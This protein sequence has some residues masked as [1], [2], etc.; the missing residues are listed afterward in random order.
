MI[1]TS[2]MSATTLTIEPVEATLSIEP[3]C[4]H[5]HPSRYE[6]KGGHVLFAMEPGTD[7]KPWYLCFR[8]WLEGA[9]RTVKND[10][11]PP[12]VQGA[13]VTNADLPRVETAP[14]PASQGGGASP[15]PRGGRKP[16]KRQSGPR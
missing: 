11:S 13:M 10:E 1:P 14:A 15:S 8:C 2:S 16:G 9:T 5:C 12:A 4:E 3:A 7:G 6:R